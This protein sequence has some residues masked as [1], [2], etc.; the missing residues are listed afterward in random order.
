MKLSTPGDS[1]GSSPPGLAPLSRVLQLVRRVVRT[2][3]SV[4]QATVIDSRIGKYAVVMLLGLLAI[5]IATSRPKRPGIANSLAA[6]W[7]LGA[8]WIGLSV[9]SAPAGPRAYP[10]GDPRN[11]IEAV[12]N[13]VMHLARWAQSRGLP[14]PPGSLSGLEEWL[15]TNREALG[16]EWTA[17]M[18]GI[19]AA[20]G[21]ALRSDSPSL[22]WQVRSGEPALGRPRSLW[23]PRRIF[24]DVHDAVFSD[25]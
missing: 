19:V 13:H 21:E 7:A 20:Y 23:P 12:P 1:G 11:F 16:H 25:C 3:S 5:V 14:P 4:G 8:L 15:W 24:R 9:K 22:V 18:A 2:C 17:L 6:A 10:L